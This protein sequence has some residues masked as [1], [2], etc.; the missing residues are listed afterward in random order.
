MGSYDVQ[1]FNLA[2]SSKVALRGQANATDAVGTGTMTI[3]AG[4]TSVDIDITDA[5]SNL[6]GIRDAIN[7]KSADSVFPPRWSATP[8]VVAVRVW[9]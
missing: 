6:A 3:T 1:V 4:D 7:A 9:S 2:Q 5:N 8:T